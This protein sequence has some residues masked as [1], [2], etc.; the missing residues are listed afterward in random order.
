MIS[1][2]LRFQGNTSLDAPLPGNAANCS[3]GGASLESS[4]PGAQHILASG[5]KGDG[6][7]KVAKPKRSPPVLSSS[8]PRSLRNA[9]AD[10]QS[11]AA[12][13]PMV[14]AAP[15][16]ASFPPFA[17]QHLACHPPLSCT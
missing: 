9:G 4:L 15:R 3:S 12:G 14:G 8:K 16:H 17:L 10:V 11:S 13:S 1:Q 2:H 7:L 6:G 5:E